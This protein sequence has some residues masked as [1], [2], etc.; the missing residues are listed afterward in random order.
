MGTVA[1]AADYNGVVQTVSALN[2]TA[3]GRLGTLAIQTNTGVHRMSGQTFRMLVGSQKMRSTFATEFVVS[4]RRLHVRGRGF[5][6]G[7]GLS[8]VSAH[9]MATD[10]HPA[11]A[12]IAHFYPAAQLRRCW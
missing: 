1:A 11:T 9:A 7:V 8:Q 3:S 5:G 6:H 2:R 12:I 10:G 4:G